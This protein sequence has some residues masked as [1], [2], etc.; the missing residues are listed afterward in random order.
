VEGQIALEPLARPT[1][2]AR[3]EK[4]VKRLDL[5]AYVVLAIG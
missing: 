2:G 5:A 4:A 3:S 1:N